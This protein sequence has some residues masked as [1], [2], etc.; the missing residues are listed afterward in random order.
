MKIHKSVI[1]VQ[2]KLKINISKI[3]NIVN[4]EIIY[5]V[6]KKNYIVFHNGSNYDYHFIVNNLAE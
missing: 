5:S 6:P 2:K 1:F 3:R 4:L